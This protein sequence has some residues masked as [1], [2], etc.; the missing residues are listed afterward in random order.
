MVGTSITMAAAARMLV[1]A[2]ALGALA[3]CQGTPTYGTGTRADKQLMEDLTGIVSITPKR[4][5]KIDYE[6]RPELVKPA[7]ANALPAPQESITASAAENGAWPE[8]PEERRKR[9]REYGTENRDSPNYKPLVRSGREEDPDAPMITSPAAADRGQYVNN[10][11]SATAY[12]RDQQADY[13]A[14]QQLSQQ[15]YADRRTY[16]SEPPLEYRQPAPGASADELGEDEDKKER[17]LKAE[18]RKNSGKKS[19]RD[20]LPWN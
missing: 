5:P 4:G 8:S 20:F 14:R 2:V 12:N 18:S 11:T 9:L 16:L 17:R 7:D 6:P 19:W 15:G 13:R 10:V 3:G 1:G